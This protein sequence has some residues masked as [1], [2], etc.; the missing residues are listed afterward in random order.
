M[1]IALANKKQGVFTSDGNAKSLNIG[2]LPDVIKVENMNAAGGEVYQ[3]VFNKAYG[4][5]ELQYTLTP[6]VSY[7]SSGQVIA[8]LES[9]SVSTVTVDGIEDKTLG[10]T[11]GFLIA[12]GFMDAADTIVWEAGLYNAD[13]MDET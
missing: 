5:D 12:A 13:Y 10:G 2:F 3:A 1:A 6:T 9:T 8:L 7:A 4:G 11:K